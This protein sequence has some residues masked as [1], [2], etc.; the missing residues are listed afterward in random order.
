MEYAV[1]FKKKNYK[2]YLVSDKKS[3]L[4]EKAGNAGILTFSVRAGNLS[5]LNPFKI[6]KLFRFYRKEKID[7]VIFSTS[8]DLKLG[9][10]SGK[11]A[12]VQN[13]VYLRGLAVPVKASLVNRFIYKK[14]LTHIVANSEETKRNILK[15][16]NK[17]IDAQKVKTI[18]HGIELNDNKVGT[19][20]KLKEIREKGRGVI[21]GNAGRLTKQKGHDQLIEIASKIKENGIDFT[22]FI[23]GTGERHAE[24]ER[25]IAKNNLTNEVILLGFVE[26]IQT[27]MNS[28]DI[29]LLTSEWEGFGYVLVEAMIQSKPVVAFNIT[30]NPEI[31]TADVTGFLADYPDTD[32]FTEKTIKLVKDE[33]L[34]KVMGEAGRKSVHERFG[35]SERITE[36]EYYLLGKT[37]T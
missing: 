14:A 31:V 37:I 29:F 20:E 1:E 36:F 15:N 8:Q 5:F 4:S 17:Y 19:T 3:P 27:F 28:I 26:N 13:I 25:L 6:A 2:V 10:I 33:S 30:S 18:Y 16:L 11:L 7:T 22:L 35:L 24:I 12:G 23:A 21:L 9:S 32:M 34:R